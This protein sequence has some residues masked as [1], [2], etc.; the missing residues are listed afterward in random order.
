[1]DSYNEKV[2]AQPDGSITAP[3]EGR[4]VDWSLAL[5]ID[6]ARLLATSPTMSTG[7]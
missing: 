3:T 5:A 1:M 2:D 7:S 6:V 4:T